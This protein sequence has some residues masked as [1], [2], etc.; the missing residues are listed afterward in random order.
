[1]RSILT[2]VVVLSLCAMAFAQPATAVE[3]GRFND[4]NFGIMHMHTKIGSFKLINGTGRAD[5]SFTGTMLISGYKGDAMIVTGDLRK[6]YDAHGRITYFGK[7]RIIFSGTWRGIQWF[8]RDMQTV[9]YGNGVARIR[10]EF[11]KDLNTGEYW[12]EDIS[13]KGYW[14]TQGTMDMGLPPPKNLGGG[15]FKP[16]RRDKTGPVKKG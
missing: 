6:E 7:G 9:W 3:K 5:I 14:Q 13:K 4:P 2:S 11:D 12:Y 10:G 16:T 15:G 8:G 1:M